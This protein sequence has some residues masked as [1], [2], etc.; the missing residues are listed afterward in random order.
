MWESLT[1]ASLQQILID[2]SKARVGE[3]ARVP[4]HISEY[5]LSKFDGDTV[6]AS[7]FIRKYCP[8]QSD[9]NII[10]HKIMSETS[11]ESQPLLLLDEAYVTPLPKI[12]LYS[13]KL[14][15]LD[16]GTEIYTTSKIVRD[17]LAILRHGAWGTIALAYDGEGLLTG[18]K[19][20]VM[21]GFKP[22]ETANADLNILMNARRELALD[23]W[24][25]LLLNTCGVNPEVYDSRQKLLYLTRLLPLIEE[26]VYLLEFGGRA[27]GKTY[28]YRNISRYTRIFSGGG[29]SPAVL[30]YNAMTKSL[31]ELGVRDCIIFDEISRIEFT[32]P[33]EMTGK[34]KD[35]MESGMFERGVAKQ[36]RSGCSIVMQGNIES[37][38]NEWD[39]LLPKSLA[40][41]ALIDRINGLIPGWEMP[42]IMSSETHLS[43]GLGISVDYFSEI[44]H[45]MRY[46]SVS[47]IIREKIELMNEPTI[48]DERSITKLASAIYKL[49][50]P[51]LEYDREVLEISMDLSIELRN[52][53]REKLHEMVPEEFSSKPIEWR[54]K[55]G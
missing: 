39:K 49:L 9:S 54:F 33:S 14:T 23:E 28:I 48:R 47:G 18:K 13:V 22:I 3:L 50:R 30:F 37:D 40:E 45:Q 12:G 29:V 6:K 15:Q 55:N 42:K 52:R 53:I 20:I 46:I 51:D 8:P 7:N 26:N 5:L 21:V 41:P 34:L 19:C 16:L 27:T 38:Y 4:R 35:Y 11:L 32:E 36:I 31:G 10:L 24:I 1:L 17:N 44:L 43:K 2:K 25:N